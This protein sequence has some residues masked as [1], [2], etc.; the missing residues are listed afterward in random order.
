MKQLPFFIVLVLFVCPAW[1]QKQIDSL[2]NELRK[3]GLPDSTR[4]DLF[5]DLS[6]Y[7]AG[8]DPVIG[9]SYSDSAYFSGA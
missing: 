5:N 2:R 1:G 3:T 7:F 4:V 9:L 8:V 6:F